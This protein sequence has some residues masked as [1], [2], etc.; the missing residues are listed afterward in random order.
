[1]YV[2]IDYPDGVTLLKPTEAL[3]PSEV[4]IIR[5]Q[6]I[7]ASL[8]AFA[9]KEIKH[10][11]PLRVEKAILRAYTEGKLKKQ[12]T[13]LTD[14]ELLAVWQIGPK[15]LAHIKTAIKKDKGD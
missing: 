6:A 12:I 10:K 15:A 8:V 9:T 3:T 4:K 2:R 13:E 11:V 14:K 1:M 5:E 7:E